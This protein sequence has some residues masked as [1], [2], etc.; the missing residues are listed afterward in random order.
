MR[1]FALTIATPDGNLYAGQAISLTVRGCE[2]ELA[3][4]AGHVPFVTAVKPCD[5]RV[6][7]DAE[8]LRTGHTDGGILSVSEKGVTLLSGSF[9]W[10]EEKEEK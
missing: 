2:G 5:C 9:G 7:T 3:V 4:L 1:T 10:T 6:L 8:Q